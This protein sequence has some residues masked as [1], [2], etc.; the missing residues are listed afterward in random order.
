M[1]TSTHLDGLD[2]RAWATATWSAP[3]VTQLV[4]ALLIAS[5]WVLGKWFPGPALPLFATSAAGVFVLCAVATF[6]LIRSTSSRAH[7][8]ALSVAGSYVVV[9]VGAT[10]YGIW[11]LQW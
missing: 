11:M 2:A 10:V 1:T 3:L 7:G 6:V 8:M 5:A 4:L 9:L